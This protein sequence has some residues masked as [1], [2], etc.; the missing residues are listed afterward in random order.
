MNKIHVLYH[1]NC[2]DGLG[3]AYSALEYARR[4]GLEAVLIPVN[5]KEDPPDVVGKTVFVVDFS[6]PREVLLRMHSQAK[7]L[8]VLDHHKTAQDDLKDLPFAH[9]DM[10]KSGAVMA[11][12]YFNGS[13]KKPTLLS[14]IQDRDLWKFE[15]RETRNV[16]AALYSMLDQGVDMIARYVDKGDSGIEELNRVG[17]LINVIF[18]KEVEVF[19]KHPVKIS[20]NG[21]VGLACNAPAKYASELGGVLC[22]L[23]GSYGATFTFS[24]KTKSWQF[25]LRSVGDYDVSEIAKHFGGGG[26]RNAAGFS[27]DCPKLTEFFY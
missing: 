6:Y 19:A 12:E 23:S 2:L 14:I 22:K 9:F 18:D 13:I 17:G 21:F 4:L 24:G 25:S 16:T 1:D 3:A 20:L 5:Y 7:L 8:V 15:F 10:Q 11:W 27:V 26:H